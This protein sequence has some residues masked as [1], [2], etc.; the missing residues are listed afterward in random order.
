M[1][2]HLV[3][4]SE[5]GRGQ[6]IG[7]FSPEMLES[8]RMGANMNNQSIDH[9][10]NNE[11]SSSRTA[12]PHGPWVIHDTKPIYRDSYIHVWRDDVTRPDQ[13]PGQHVV[14]EMKPG[15]CVIP[16]DEQGNVTLTSEFHYA[17]G[18]TSIEGVSGGIEPGEDAMETAKRELGEELGLAADQWEFLAESNPFTTIIRS[19]T[20]LYLAKALTQIERNLEGTEIITPITMSIDEA[21]QAIT[22][23]DITHAPTCVA[24][25]L[26]AQKHCSRVSER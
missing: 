16:M 9:S 15:V 10:E 12:R 14:V 25:L 6:S 22:D 26:I 3:R 24:L 8:K 18:M 7:P 20:Q 2:F 21:V 11:N 13:R 5:N 23:G 17:I 1:K 19:P 4:F